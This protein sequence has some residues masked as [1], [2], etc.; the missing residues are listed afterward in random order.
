[1]RANRGL[2][3]GHA[4][5]GEVDLVDCDLGVDALVAQ[6]ADR[7]DRRAHVD[8]VCA[9]CDTFHLEGERRDLVRRHNVLTLDRGSAR[10]GQPTAIL[11]SNFAA[12]P[13]NERLASD[14]VP[15]VHATRPLFRN[16]KVI[17]ASAP[18]A[19]WAGGVWSTHALSRSDSFG[20]G[21]VAVA[22][23]VGCADVGA[24]PPR[25]ENIAKRMTPTTPAKIIAP[26]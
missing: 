9:R 7:G 8:P 4:A 12:V 18:T 6:R 17:V 10:G 25:N 14:P 20:R 23:G 22:V 24:P 13:T 16:L 2:G 1:M 19:I 26:V 15:R 21:A 5:E 11:G 3:R